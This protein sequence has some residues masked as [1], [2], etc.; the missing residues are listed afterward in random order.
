[1]GLACLICFKYTSQQRALRRVRDD[2]QAH[3]LVLKLFP[4]SLWVMLRAE[5]R[6]LRGAAM[7]LALAVVPM[8]VMIVPVSLLLGQL[9]L[10]Y[11]VRPLRIGEEAV[12]TVQLRGGAV[13]TMPD[14][15]IEPTAAAETVVGPVQVLSKREICWNI[16]A[17]QNGHHR[18]AFHCDGRTVEK[19]LAIG[20][21]FMRTSAIRPRCCWSDMLWQPAEQPFTGDS[22]IREFRLTTPPASRGS[23]AA[24]GGSPILLRPQCFLLYVFAPGLKSGCD[25]SV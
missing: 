1:M 22:S 7:L 4:D 8:L 18:L 3:L 21:G 6:L 5:G 25:D 16:R 17:C 10:W 19:E 12:V 20:D 13:S 24:I 11:Q 23:T 2:I 15:Q 14:V 9:S